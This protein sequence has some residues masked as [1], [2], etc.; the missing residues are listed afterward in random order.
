LLVESNSLQIS[1]VVVVVV[2]V[3]VAFR[4]GPRQLTT[5]Y[6]DKGIVQCEFK[7]SSFSTPYA[8][9]GFFQVTISIQ[10][11]LQKKRTR[12]KKSDTPHYF[13]MLMI[14]IFN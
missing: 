1:F 10:K 7:Y 11:I 12:K 14:W 2:V 6:S 4:Y 9:R 5:E 8:R 13:K 3:V